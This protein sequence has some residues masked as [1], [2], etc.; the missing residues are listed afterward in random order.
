MRFRAEAA[1]LV[2]LVAASAGTYYYFRRRKRSGRM[3]FE[4]PDNKHVNAFFDRNP[5]FYPAFET[6]MTLGNRCFGRASGAR[7][8]AEDV[9]FSLGHTCREDYI[10]VL[11]MA[12]SG[13]GIGALKL[14]RGLYE[15][16][17]TLAYIA[18]HPDQVERYINFTPI[19]ELRAL[20]AAL[21]IVTEKEFDE[22]IGATTTAAQIRE[23]HERIR[24]EFRG[25]QLSWL[26]LH[27][28]VKDVGGPYAHHYPGSYT[29]PNFK[30]HATLASAFDGTPEDVRAERNVQNADFALLS[31]TALFLLVIREQNTMFHLGLDAE[32][33]RCDAAMLE[34]WKPLRGFSMTEKETE[35]LVSL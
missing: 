1:W 34:A 23:A 24:P 9:C 28:I 5:K 26:P 35:P 11:F 13:Y 14:L 10:E 25:R 33:D 18:K 30:V 2:A 21:T 4:F 19:Q 32:I 31:A 20:K 3:E 22:T 16:A 7:N 8:H 29:I 12:S 17:V 27:E 6:L 15:R